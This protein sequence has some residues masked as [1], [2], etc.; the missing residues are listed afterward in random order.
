[1]K[2]KTVWEM[3]GRS[4]VVSLSAAVCSCSCEE[5]YSLRLAQADSVM[6]NR[7]VLIVGTGIAGTTLAYWLNRYGFEP[8]LIE[9]AEQLR[10]GGYVIDFWGLGYDVAEKMGLLP[11]LKEVALPVDGLKIVDERGKRRG[12]IGPRAIRS[13]LGRRYLSIL[14]SDLAKEIYGAL[15][16]GVRTIFGDTVTRLQQDEAGV[17]V[18]YR[19][20]HSERFDLVFGAGGLHS[21]IRNLLFGAESSFEKF[22][23]YYAASFAVDDYPHQDPHVFVS[24]SVPS[25]QVTRYTLKDGRTVFLFVFTAREKLSIP[26]GNAQAQK[27]V[28]KDEFAGVGWECPDMLR[29]L[30][31]N[32]EIYFDAV[33]QIRMEKWSRNR[34]T[35]VGDACACPSLLA[36]QGSALAMAGAYILAGELMLAEGNFQ[37]AFA[38]YERSLHPVIESKQRAAQKFAKSFAPQTHAG[39]FL[40]NQVTR[41]MSIPFVA[42]LAMGRM[43]KDSL[44]LPPYE[45]IQPSA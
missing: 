16:G 29:R 41:L 14:R 35:L 13:M 9:R 34:S 3:S 22:L 11:A 30:E 1:M 44:S 28:L 33:S 45:S 5:A 15:G 7:K 19:S 39:I 18:E 8:T 42:D 23:G 2:K 21:P 26:H 10:T 20:G 36:G 27:Q 24:Y 40:R 4:K 38:N 31:E 6:K 25:K 17:L 43:F 37:V 32:T 12:G